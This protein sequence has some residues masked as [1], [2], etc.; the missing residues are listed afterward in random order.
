MSEPITPK[1]AP[2]ETDA[3]TALLRAVH[4]A[5]DLPLPDITDEDEREHRALLI[6]RATDARVVLAGVLEQDHDVARAAERLRWW[7]A[8]DPVTYTPWKDKGAPA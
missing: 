6:S 2:A 8:D 4:H 5:L 1:T 7:I 3:V